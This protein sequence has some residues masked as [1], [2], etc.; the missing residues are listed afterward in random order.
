M[1]R[2]KNQRC[3]LMEITEFY[4]Q[5]MFFDETNIFLLTTG[6]NRTEEKK[7]GKQ[8]FFFGLIYNTGF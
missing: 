6:E 7:T 1:K 2:K 3:G 8:F 4:K 5:K